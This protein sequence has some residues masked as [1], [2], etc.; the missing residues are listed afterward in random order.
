MR[1][2]GLLTRLV[3]G[4]GEAEA[5]APWSH[6]P[7][8]HGRVFAH[9]PAAVLQGLTD[10]TDI[11]RTTFDQLAA[12]PWPPGPDACGHEGS[13]RRGRRLRGRPDPTQAPPVIARKHR[14]EAR[15][16]RDRPD[17]T[18]PS[19]PSRRPAPPAGATNAYTASQAPISI[20]SPAGPATRVHPRPNGGCTSDS[21]DRARVALPVVPKVVDRAA[22]HRRIVARAPRTTSPHSAVVHAGT[23]ARGRPSGAFGRERGK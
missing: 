10:P 8:L 3:W 21:E 6:G 18:L 16:L 15:R 20:R 2:G 4:P 13:A 23:G 1:R 7:D 11:R 9:R 22:R 17:P 19:S 14:A 12:A 5:P